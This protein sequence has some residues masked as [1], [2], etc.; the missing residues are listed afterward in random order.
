[1]ML[2]SCAFVRSYYKVKPSCLYYQSGY[3]HQAWQDGNLPWQAPT[4]KPL[5]KIEYPLITWPCEITWQTR[6]I[7]WCP[8]PWTMGNTFWLSNFFFVLRR[9]E[10]IWGACQNRLWRKAGGGGST[11]KNRILYMFFFFLEVVRLYSCIVLTVLS[12]TCITV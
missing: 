6:T 9:G 4:H 3:G 8:S 1:M 7:T 11:S 10:C 2:R 12:Y 5:Y